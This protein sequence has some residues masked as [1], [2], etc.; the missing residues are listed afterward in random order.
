MKL[1][2]GSLHEIEKAVLSSRLI[3]PGSRVVVGCSG[4]AD[5]LALLSVLW[6]LHGELEVEVTAAHANHQLRGA[7]SEADEAHVRQ[8]CADKGIEFERVDLELNGRHETGNLENRARIARYDF[9]ARTARIYSGLVLTGHTLDDQAETFLMKLI[10]GAGPGG[11]SGIAKR[12]FHPD[13]VSGEAVLVLRPFLAVS[14]SQIEDYLNERSIP[15]RTDR[16]N[17]D[18]TFDRNWVRRELMP[19]LEERLNP[20]VRRTLGRTARLMGE[21]EHHL[22]SEARKFLSGASLSAGTGEI[23]IPGLMELDPPLRKVAIRLA[24]DAVKGNLTDLSQGHVE[25]VLDLASG[26][27]GRRVSL[28]GGYVAVREF[29][30][31]RLGGVTTVEPVCVEFDAPGDVVLPTLGKSVRIESAEGKEGTI[32]M[33]SRR[34]RVR[35]RRPGDRFRVHPGAPLKKLKKLFLER[36]VPISERERLLVFECN[37]R[38][39]WIEGFPYPAEGGAERDGAGWFR[40]T[41][42]TFYQQ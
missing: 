6:E 25:A 18:P 21:I 3:P 38:I 37:G 22:E 5:S 28:P 13:P 15:Y 35:T 8:F 19:L 20:Q 4:G 39:V 16:S 30:R 40:V 26:T 27:S 14:R 17:L 7:E 12:R 9:L 31:L 11:L 34:V 29:D 32:W 36:R 41:V 10:R 2:S 33:P 1:R 42:E 24:I 23:S